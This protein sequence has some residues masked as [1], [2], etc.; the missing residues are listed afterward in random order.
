M[1]K[2]IIYIGSFALIALAVLLLKPVESS[3]VDDCEVINASVDKI[4]QNND[5]M[6]VINFK[7]DS[8]SFY[9]DSSYNISI[10][11]LKL[12]LLNQKIE[13][14]YFKSNSILITNPN[15]KKIAMIKYFDDVIYNELSDIADN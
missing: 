9:I 8:T 13:L 2:S 11:E 7:N 15:E 1:K 4:Y 12:K 5:G 10:D 3:Y 6:I 14:W